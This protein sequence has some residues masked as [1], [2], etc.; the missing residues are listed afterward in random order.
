[1][2]ESAVISVIQMLIPLLGQ[3]IDLLGSAKRGVEDIKRELESIRSLLKDA[4]KR[5]AQEEEDGGAGSNECVKTWVKQLREEAFRIEDTI[6]E[7][8]MNVAR[9]RGLIGYIHKAKH[10]RKIATEIQDIKLS[11]SKIKRRGEFYNF[12]YIDQGSGSGGRNVIPHDSR[13]SSFFIEDVEVVGIES[14]IEELTDLLVNRTFNIRSV[15]AVVGEGG[16][17][18][19]TL[20]GKIYNENV[21]KKHFD[22]QAWITIG[23][24]YLKKDLLRTIIQELYRLVGSTLL[25]THKMEE[26]DL[27]MMLREYLKDKCYM[28][29]FDDVWKIDFWRD[30]EHALIDNNRNSR[31]MLTARN[32]A[33]VEF[34][35]LSI[36]HVHMLETLSSEKAWELFCR[37]SFGSNNCCPPNLKELSKQII[38]KCG[39]LPLAII[40]IAGLLSRRSKIASEWRNIIDNLGSKLSNDSHLKDCNK[41]L[42][43]G[44]YDL[45]FHLKSCLLYF[46]VFPQGYEIGFGRLIRLWMAEGFVQCNNNLLSEH[47]AQEY[48]KELIDRSLVQVSKRK[49]S[50]RVESCRVHDLMYEII[51]GKMKE[52]DFCHFLNERDLDHFSK[53]RRISLHKSTNGV[54]ESIKNSKI[55]SIYL[56]NVDKLP[57]SFMI[58]LVEFKLLKI[59]DFE[60]APIDSL[61][62]GVGNLFHLHYLSLKNTN[63]KEL[64]KSV[65]MLLNLETLNLKWTPMHEF[66]VEIKNLKKLQNLIFQRLDFEGPYQD[67]VK[68]HEGFGALTKLRR[69]LR[70]HLNSEALKELMMMTQLRKLCVSL[71]NRDAKNLFGIVENMEKL[72]QL[73]VRLLTTGEE[74]VDLETVA[75]PPQCVERL[76]LAM[77]IKKVPVWICKLENLIKL[78]LRLVGSAN[79]SMRVL[80][81]LP[82]LLVF[83]VRVRDSDEE[84]HVKEGWFPKLQYLSLF[85][86]KELKWL[87]IEKGAMPSLTE[88]LIGPC[89]LLKEIPIGIEHLRNLKTLV[90]HMMLKEVYCMVKNDNWKKLT[91]HIPQIRATCK[92]IRID[93]YNSYTT[94]YLSS[95]SA[96]DFEKLLEDIKYKD[97]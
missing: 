92:R 49:A 81:T 7:Y 39:G 11:L 68:I 53:T 38:G 87:M 8:I 83:S 56:F 64:P 65:G 17:G 42:S 62:D 10:R 34:I 82:N 77:Y 44:Y 22:C 26:R 12:R 33:V 14:T 59:L 61:P 95:L 75:S 66:S 6:D 43:E 50:G 60:N 72:E 76:G 5:A 27:I 84:L 29:V 74:I 18:K 19:T 48:L 41:V 36:V 94:K 23:R 32:K 55:R 9:G 21:V 37:K 51:R 28:I 52:C 2:A 15:I 3:E 96:E 4:D 85:D 35:P 20:V 30:I 88:L 70:V 40:A 47:V 25:E 67:A 80:Q 13:V 91:N 71:A 1:M 46:G 90:F 78:K 31:V 16:L 45:P 93:L 63:V 86:I 89:P 73:S 57:K 24:E 97:Y 58:T 79:D 54:L 69:L